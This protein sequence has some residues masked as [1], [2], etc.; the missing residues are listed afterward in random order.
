MVSLIVAAALAADSVTCSFVPS[1]A[2]AK[3]GG[4]RPVRSE[5]STTKPASVKRV[6]TGLS[7]PRFGEMT[8]EGTNVGYIL[9]GDKV[10]VDANRNGD[11]TDDPAVKWESQRNGAIWMGTATVEINRPEKVGINFYHF[12]E[13][14]PNRAELKNTMLYYGDYGLEVTITLD[15]KT[16]KSFVAGSVD[17]NTS[18]WVDRNGDGQRS[19]YYEMIK[20]DKPFNFTGKTYELKVAKNGLALIKSDQTVAQAPMPPDLTVGKQ[21]IKFKAKTMSGAD[22]DFPTTYKGKVV[23][24]DFWATWCGPCLQE[25]PNVSKAYEKFHSRGFE[26]LGISFDDKDAVSKIKETAQKMNMPWDH[27]Y[28]G[29][30]WNTELGHTFDVSAIPFALLVDGTTGKILATGDT[31]RGQGL[32]KAL[33]SKLKAN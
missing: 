9:S 30:G 25:M 21:V 16:S 6:P 24:L 26:I 17:S 29:K 4:Y 33:E 7:E 1:G 14:D 32:E 3:A 20:V 10:Y 13:T 27:V 18:L 11:Y 5:M 15:G 22:V 12:S 2:V 19:Y 23:L 8:F 28:E 31:L